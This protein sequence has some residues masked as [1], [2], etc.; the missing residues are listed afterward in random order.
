MAG[1]LRSIAYSFVLLWTMLTGVAHSFAQVSPG[2][3]AHQAGDYV[4]A[5]EIFGKEAKAGSAVA[6]YN[7]GVMY[8]DGLGVTPDP[9]EAA[10]WFGLAADSG[11]T[12]AEVELGLLYAKGSG[13]PRDNKKAVELW[14]KAAAAGN[15]RAAHLLAM[16][17]STDVGPGTG[18]A[19]DNEK[20]VDWFRQ[21]AEAGLAES[22]FELGR[23]LTDGSGVPRDPVAGMMWLML[24]REN[25]PAARSL[26][27]EYFERAERRLSDQQLAQ[28][29]EK[30]ESCRKSNYRNCG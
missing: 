3:A 13:V 4:K 11:Y 16:Q 22:Q 29:R 2:N 21:A 30:A 10:N 7:L 14:Q 8:L 28:A 23:M 5:L 27:L 20:A 15:S 12:E 26:D 17:Y 25:N 24:A 9:A 1:H 19:R 18:V 6:R